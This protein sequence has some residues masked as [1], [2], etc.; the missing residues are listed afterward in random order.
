[1]PIFYIIMPYIVGISFFPPILM[2]FTISLSWWRQRRWSL[3][4]CC[5]EAT[6]ARGVSL[7]QHNRYL[8]V[9]IV[10]NI[11][12]ENILCPQTV[13]PIMIILWRNI[14]K[15]RKCVCPQWLEPDNWALSQGVLLGAVWCCLVLFGASWG[16]YV[17]LLLLLSF[18]VRVSFGVGAI[19]ICGGVIML[20]FIK[21]VR[22]ILRKEERN[23]RMPWIVFKSYPGQHLMLFRKNNFITSVSYLLFLW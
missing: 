17:V 21:G 4:P 1:M 8:H 23:R 15:K 16:G 18:D 6:P 10:H 5:T 14:S 13:C 3:V 11:K 7:C 19:M 12:P 9:S 20:V 22:V 2:P